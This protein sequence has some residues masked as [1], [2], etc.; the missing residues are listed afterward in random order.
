MTTLSLRSNVVLIVGLI[1][2]LAACTNVRAVELVPFTASYELDLTKRSLDLQGGEAKIVATLSRPNCMIAET[3]YRFNAR[4]QREDASVVTEQHTVAREDF[5]A[6]TFTFRTDTLVDGAPETTIRG[7]ASHSKERTQV[8]I[9]EPEQAS[10]SLPLSVFPSA[11]TADL[12]ERAKAGKRM[13]ETRLYDGDNEAGKRLTTTAIIA[14]APVTAPSATPGTAQQ[15][16]TLPGTPSSA[17]AGL[18]HW[19]ISEAYYNSDGDADGL[20]LFQT[21]YTLYENG[22]SDALVIDTGDYAFAGS[23]SDLTLGE[24]PDCGKHR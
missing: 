20:P 5:T 19:R 24:A 6:G 2:V 13:V 1:V 4:F 17:L 7:S 9:A 11:H 3:D 12:I 18:R 15:S 22:V 16:A 8:E 10:F 21:S 23:L 14:S